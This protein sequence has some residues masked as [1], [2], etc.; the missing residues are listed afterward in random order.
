[1]EE[2]IDFTGNTANRASTKPASS[3]I[4]GGAKG[5]GLVPI[6]TLEQE[7]SAFE[8][9]GRIGERLVSLGVI[10]PDQLNVALSE[11]KISGKMLGQVMVDLGFID[12]STLSKFLAEASGFEVF[13]PKNTI[14]DGDALSLLKKDDAIKLNVLPYFH[15]G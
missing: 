8:G 10:T 3:S 2:I 12:E 1:M 13:D 11:K 14:F 9:K 4:A 15:T 6:R 5:G 7:N